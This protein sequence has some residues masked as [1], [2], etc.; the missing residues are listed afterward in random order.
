MVKAKGEN[1]H[2]PP[3]LLEDSEYAWGNEM[4]PGGRHLANSR[5]GD[6]RWQNLVG[7]GYDRTSPVGAFPANAIEPCPDA[8]RAGAFEPLMMGSNFPKR[9]R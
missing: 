2:C 1:R 9:R 6:F 3:N 7:D 4:S 5:Q 8:T